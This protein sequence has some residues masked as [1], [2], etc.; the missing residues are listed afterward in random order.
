MKRIKIPG[1][2]LVA[3]AV[4][5]LSA[6]SV[7]A[8]E[9]AETGR[10]SAVGGETEA[11]F[12]KNEVI[13]GVLSASGEVEAL[14][15][16]NHFTLPQP[17]WV[18]D[19]GDYT[20]VA[21]LTDPGALPWKDG[22]VE[23]YTEK[24]N[25][26]YRGDLASKELP[27]NFRI[28]YYLDGAVTPP[29][30]AA[31]KSGTLE[32]CVEVTAN[33]EAD[34][35]F[36]NNYMIQV[37][38]TLDPENCSDIAAPGATI[39]A[40]G[41]NRL[42][43]FLVLPG[44]GGTLRTR[45]AASDFSMPGIEISAV[46]LS[47]HLNLPD[48]N[49]MTAEFQSLAD[50]I[51]ALNDGASQLYDGAARLAQGADGL[52]TGSGQI[53]S[54]LSVLGGGS[55]Q[56]SEGSAQIAQ[57]LSYIAA[58]AGASAFPDPEQLENLA[59]L[60]DSFSALAG[61]L[62]EISDGLRELKDAFVPAYAA[63]DAAIRELP[64]G[65]LSPEQ[66]EALAASAAP[67]HAETIAAL[68]ASYQ[69]A[70]LVRETYFQVKSAFDAIAPGLDALSS[71]GDALSGAAG[72][73]SEEML[74]ALSGLDGAAQLQQAAA[75]LVQLNEQY[76]AFHAGLLS[77]AAGVAEIAVKYGTLD[78]GISQL[79]SGAAELEGGF[80][81]FLEGLGALDTETSDMPERLRT[82]IDK[83]ISQSGSPDFRAVSFLSAENERI[84][85]VQFVLKCGG[86]EPDV[87]KPQPAAPKEKTFWD[88]FKALFGG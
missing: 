77:Y 26:Y 75:G 25:F 76:A 8:S 55:A 54:G 59:R 19:V 71:A 21:N 87:Q 86:V 46:P 48:T 22:R 3:V 20:A 80:S 2:L 35:V 24:K 4:M 23:F 9:P 88:R 10:G 56:L 67:E 33:P 69:A 85:S 16:V 83:W 43:T 39:A 38:L 31:G 64:A 66:I 47:L 73:I 82:E 62:A 79:R 74:S 81:A 53:N 40:A 58:A 41:S 30:N 42:V 1:V 45:V 70:Q 65:D 32:I 27:W 13:Y 84:E 63:L 52:E 60:P 44:Q 57:A 17:G 78:S 12:T 72:K 36:Y 61:G 29:Q 7:P 51:S 50:A 5:L 49:Q 68:A 11:A 6:A 28:T 15:A 18:R 34:P 37:S 14:Y